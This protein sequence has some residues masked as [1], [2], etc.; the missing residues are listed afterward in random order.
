MNAHA[1]LIAVAVGVLATVTMDIAGVIALRL[2]IAGRGPR[3]T[4]PDLIGRWVGYML[5]GK[6]KH[7]DILETP[8][9]PREVPLGLATHYLIGIVLTLLYLVILLGARA[10]PSLLSAVL[11]GAVTTVL[12]WF[13]MFPSEGMGWLG[14]DTPEHAHMARMS[15]FNHLMFGLGLALWTAVL[16]PL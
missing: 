5:R 4:G 13:I 10:V 9:L 2:G 7:A 3:R 11:F 12:P 6:F 16:R 14:Q 15:L 1:F 8:A